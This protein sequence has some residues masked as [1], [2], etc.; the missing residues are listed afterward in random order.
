MEETKRN[1]LHQY[2]QLNKYLCV[3]RKN[4]VMKYFEMPA[5]NAEEDDDNK[6]PASNMSSC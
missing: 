5:G 6:K 2:M 1:N 3:N 4:L